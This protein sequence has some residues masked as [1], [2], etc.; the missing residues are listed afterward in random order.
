MKNTTKQK[1][2]IFIP[3]KVTFNGKEYPS[4]L[5]LYEEEKNRMRRYHHRSPAI[6]YTKFTYIIKRHTAEV[7]V[8]HMHQWHLHSR[9]KKR[10]LNVSSRNLGGADNLVCQRMTK[11]G[12]SYEKAVST[13]VIRSRGK[14]IK[15]KGRHYKSI[16]DCWEAV[17]PGCSYASFLRRLSKNK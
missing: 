13:P 16:K 8:W 12:W 15:Y 7:A 6:D 5:S 2:G 17:K 10:G 9:S 3:R 4:M 1:H 14:P 11:L